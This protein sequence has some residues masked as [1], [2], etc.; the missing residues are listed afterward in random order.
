[1]KMGRDKK[2]KKW[3]ADAGAAFAAWKKRW[4]VCVFEKERCPL[5]C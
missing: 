4:E 2:K 1:M 3:V 5:G